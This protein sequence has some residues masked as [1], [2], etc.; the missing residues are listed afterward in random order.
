MIFFSF[1]YSIIS[2]FLIS[3]LVKVEEGRKKTEKNVQIFYS[4]YKSF[5]FNSCFDNFVNINHI[6]SKLLLLLLLL[7]FFLLL[8]FLILIIRFSFTFQP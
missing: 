2:K 8:L 6:K 5:F 1:N 7:F 3:E 4:F